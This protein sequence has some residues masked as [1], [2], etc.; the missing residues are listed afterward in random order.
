MKVAGCAPDGYLRPHG[1]IFPQSF[2]CVCA[3]E[4]VSMSDS[5]YWALTGC[6]CLLSQ[7]RGVDAL[8]KTLWEVPACFY[9][10]YKE[11]G[12]GSFGLWENW[13]D[14][15]SC[16]ELQFFC[17]WCANSLGEWLSLLKTLWF[18]VQH[19]SPSS[20]NTNNK[21]AFWQRI[22]C[23]HSFPPSEE[24][25]SMSLYHIFYFLS[26]WLG[27]C[28]KQFP[29][30]KQR[31]TGEVM[32]YNQHSLFIWRQRRKHSRMNCCF[33]RST[34]VQSVTSKCKSGERPGQAHKCKTQKSVTRLFF[35][36]W[37]LICEQ[38]WLIW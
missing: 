7:Q 36:S 5:C 13:T 15:C 35:Q 10:L 11:P 23:L 34:I 2:R 25:Y 18:Q 24:A 26:L 8:L 19:I 32:A 12:S 20:H 28:A 38:D 17:S 29:T 31:S 22:T 30:A 27:C 37:A 6:G 1:L 21:Q 3:Q 9:W 16:L 14:W 33:Y 4:G